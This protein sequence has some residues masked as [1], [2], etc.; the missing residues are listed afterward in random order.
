MPR[1]WNKRDPNVPAD[2]VYVGRPTIW[3]NK[4][5]HMD[6]TKAEYR[7]ATREEAVSVYRAYAATFVDDIKRELRGRDLICWC[8]PAIC[9]AD[10]L[11]EIANEPDPCPIC[12]SP[13]CSAPDEKTIRWGF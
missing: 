4:W 12:G 2:A 9:H 7:V 13:G 8:A 6:D 10:V 1:V 5:S 3:G 11:L